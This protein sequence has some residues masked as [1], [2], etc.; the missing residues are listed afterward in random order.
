M[1]CSWLTLRT[2]TWRASRPK[3]RVPPGLARPRRWRLASSHL[4]TPGHATPPIM[5]TK[6]ERLVW[7]AQLARVLGATQVLMQTIWECKGAFLLHGPAGRTARAL[8]WVPQGVWW[9]RGGGWGKNRVIFFR[10]P[11]RGYPPK[12]KLA[13][14]V[15]IFFAKRNF[16]TVC[17]LNLHVTFLLP[18][19]T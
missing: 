2:L 15:G 6:Y 9:P 4:L 11:L 7:P 18:H 10:T 14:H 17:Y 19:C 12:K 5:R 1:V 13:P 16:F 8:G 3:S